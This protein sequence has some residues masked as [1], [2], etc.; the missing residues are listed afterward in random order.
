MHELR[1]AGDA[2]VQDMRESRLRVVLRPADRHM[3]GVRVRWKGADSVTFREMRPGR[4]YGPCP[5]RCAIISALHMS[6]YLHQSRQVG[7]FS[8][9]TVPPQK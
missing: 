3:Q 2:L 4:T 7:S 5:L 6:A 9:L 8:R 1:T